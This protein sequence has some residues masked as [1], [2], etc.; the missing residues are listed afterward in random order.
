VSTMKSSEPVPQT[1]RIKKDRETPEPGI[2]MIGEIS[3]A[4]VTDTLMVCGNPRVGVGTQRRLAI[5]RDQKVLGRKHRGKP[6]RHAGS[7]RCELI[8]HGG[9]GTPVGRRRR[10]TVSGEHGQS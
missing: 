3:C 7:R 5:H 4:V 10:F 2:Y 1:S 9:C 6:K 8:Q